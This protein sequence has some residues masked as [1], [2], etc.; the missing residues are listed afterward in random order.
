MRIQVLLLRAPRLRRLRRPQQRLPLLRAAPEAGRRRPSSASASDRPS[1]KRTSAPRS[2]VDSCGGIFYDEQTATANHTRILQQRMRSRR[3]PRAASRQ[4]GSCSRARGVSDFGWPRQ[5]L[6]EYPDAAFPRPV[7][8][9]F[10]TRVTGLLHSFLVGILCCSITVVD[11][12]R[13]EILVH[14]PA[15]ME[16]A[17][18]TKSF[19]FDQVYGRT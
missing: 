4:Q 14:N 19:T 5:T 10:S 12:A 9:A 11:S 18:T 17:S 3:C 8:N 15:S 1:C 2:R 16:D 7:F 13:G 6:L